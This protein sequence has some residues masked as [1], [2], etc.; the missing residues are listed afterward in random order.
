MG[1]GDRVHECE[2]RPHLRTA[3]TDPRI[4][5]KN[6]VA[7]HRTAARPGGLYSYAHVPWTSRGQRLFDENDLPSADLK[8]QLYRLGKF[9]FSINGY[10]DI[11][12]DH[13]AL[14]NDELFKARRGPATPQFH[15]LYYPGNAHPDRLRRIQ[16]Q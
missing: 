14:K 4:H 12:M 9:L 11:G 3:Q 6:A 8:M 13:F 16:Y 7:M 5:R 10:S 15:G 1:A 2:L